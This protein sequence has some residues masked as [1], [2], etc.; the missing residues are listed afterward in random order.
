MNH[1]CHTQNFH[2]AIVALI[3]T[4]GD[5]FFKELQ[6]L[7][8]G[9]GVEVVVFE[10]IHSYY[11]HAKGSEYKEVDLVLFLPEELTLI[12][13]DMIGE[14]REC[15][16]A[17]KLILFF[18]KWDIGY[19]ELIREFHISFFFP[20][21]LGSRY[22]LPLFGELISGVRNYLSGKH[23]K[24]VLIKHLSYNYPS[25]LMLIDIDNF[26]RFNDFYGYEFGDRIII[27]CSKLLEEYKPINSHLY[28]IV[29]DTFAILI[30]DENPKL[31]S[32]FATMINILAGEN[33]ISIN[34][35]ELSLTF[36]IGISSGRGKKLLEEAKKAL[37][38]AK[39]I[40]KKHFCIYKKESSVT[41]SMQNNNLEWMKRVKIALETNSISPWYQPILNNATQKIEKFECLVRLIEKESIFTPG[42]FLEPAKMIGVMPN[43]SYSIINKSFA[44]FQHRE[45]DFSINVSEEDFRSERFINYLQNRIEFYGIDPKRITLEI[46]ESVG[47]GRDNLVR[48]QLIYLKS[49]GLK[50]AIDDFG[51][52]FSNFSRLFEME[53]DYIKIDGSFIKNIDTDEK[54]YK[55]VN[56]MVVF[57]H[58]IGAKVIAEFVH[59]KKVFDVVKE[60]GIE[61]SQGYY[62]AGPSS[63]PAYTPLFDL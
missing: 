22:F 6:A 41:E 46:L 39:H 33:Y 59:S 53:I 9:L 27:E 24:E 34:D 50:L 48:E 25:S 28:H 11:N 35:I 49:M 43:I 15:F 20:K 31:A 14:Y 17:S 3:G 23:N 60:L 55:A 54:S 19:E 44:L 5:I 58:S 62:I 30:E 10:D 18:D 1:I 63:E 7:L 40:G 45:G 2:C 61:Y 42:F 4:K 57:A 8:E 37:K 29:G 36:T 16:G 47:R 32:D 56:S 26:D 21:N 52:E 51:V 13:G 12:D 38:D